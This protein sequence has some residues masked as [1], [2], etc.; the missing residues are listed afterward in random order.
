MYHIYV[1]NS[2]RPNYYALLR[3]KELILYGLSVMVRNNFSSPSQYCEFCSGWEVNENKLFVV[4]SLWHT[5][6]CTF[7][8]NGY[9]SSI[10]G[11]SSMQ[12]L[13]APWEFYSALG[14]S[15]ESVQWSCVWWFGTGGFQALS[16]SPFYLSL[17]FLK[18]SFLFQPSDG[19]CLPL[20]I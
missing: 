15:M 19:Q 7:L 20:M 6:H 8:C 1:Q 12:N 13:T 17:G 9:S 4:Q 14:F 18:F 10:I 5:C 11:A 16:Q 2:T 3:N